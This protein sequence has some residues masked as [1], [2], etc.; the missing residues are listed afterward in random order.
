MANKI[1]N[2]EDA[3]NLVQDGDVM[4]VSAFG[5]N[6]QPREILAK[7][8]EKFLET[9]SPK[10]LT[11]IHAAGHGELSDHCAHEGML[12]R[13]IGGH[14][15]TSHAIGEMIANNKV[16]AYN[17]PQGVISHLFR[18]AGD[19]SKAHITKVGLKTY[20]DP[21]LEG[22]KMNELTKEDLVKVIELEGEE[23]LYYPT[24][25]I[26]LGI[27][28]GTIAD[29]DGNICIEEETLPIDSRVIA[30]AAKANGGRV[31]AQVKQV[32]PA[33]SLM[34]N[35][36][37]I[38]GIFVDAVVVCSDPVK[39][40]RQTSGTYYDQTLAGRAYVALE[41]AARLKLDAKK[42]IARRCAVELVPGAVVNLG[43]GTPEFV[44]QVA[45]EEG[46]S[47]DV[48]M[49]AE[50]GVIG[51]VPCGGGDFGAARN[52]AAAMEQ[53]N[54][55]DFYDG[56]GLDVTYLGLAE[57][58][59]KGDVNVSWFGS[60]P[61]GC[62]GFINISQNTKNIVYCG[63]FTAGGLKETFGDGKMTIVQEGK[64][65]KFINKVQQV[66]YS[67]EYGVE[68]GQN[69]LFVTERAVFRLTEKGLT[70]TEIA[71]GV[72]L[73]KD[74]L[75]Q[76]EFTPAIAEP[77]QTMDPALFKEENFGLKDILAAKK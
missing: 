3:L 43:V 16:E 53:V 58:N 38:P 33:G 35:R 55:F 52:A 73:Q 6:G 14:F 18:C 37:H 64:S 11:Y 9:G 8:E 51:G 48:I 56:G 50:S 76:M 49:T 40:H 17:L 74:V 66:T 20:I 4:A 27:I 54:Q 29:T 5:S 72:D 26:T 41:G 32:V 63:T 36:V 44:A 21:R 31:I 61:T 7:L 19:G 69:V 62:G 67:G 68:T 75:D 45:A 77:L 30:M 60:K 10:N 22:G 59:Q 2:I 65:K 24:P 1:Y 39:Y 34:T 13:I 46:C 47:S 57:A 25:K 12:K 70:L 42:V 71:P 23:F 15:G 28:R